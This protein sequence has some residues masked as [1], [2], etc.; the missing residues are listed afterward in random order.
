V[1]VRCVWIASGNNP[2]VSNTWWET[3]GNS[4]VKVS[5]LWDQIKN[6][7]TL[8]ISGDSEQAQKIRLGKL[9]SDKRDRTFSVEIDGKGRSARLL[10][11]TKGKLLKATCNKHRTVYNAL[12]SRKL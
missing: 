9:L 2:S 1:P 11:A 5:E 3:F 7:T 10:G 12:R 4:E 6:D 8:P